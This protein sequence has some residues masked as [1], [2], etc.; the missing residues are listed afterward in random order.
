MTGASSIADGESH[1]LDARVI[2]LDRLVGAINVAVLAAV[3]LVVLL[4]VVFSR[5]APDWAL[6]LA[7]LVWAAAVFGLALRAYW[8]PGVS[9]RYASY[10][11]DGLG[12]EIRRGVIWRRVITVP[13]SRVQ[14]TDVAQG[15]LERSYGLGTLL[16]HTAGTDHARVQVWGLDHTVASRIRDHLLP[17]EGG[18]AV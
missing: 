10:R 13:R 18:D 2:A 15:P 11:V 14:H 6:P 5:R 16:I 1:P 12:I 7:A 4:V 17:D 8:W 9:Y 3:L